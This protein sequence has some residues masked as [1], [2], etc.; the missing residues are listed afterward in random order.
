MTAQEFITEA[1]ALGLRFHR[2]GERL[3]VDAE[4]GSLTADVKRWLRDEKE[5][6]LRA[7]DAASIPEDVEPIELD[8]DGWPVGSIEPAEPCPTCGGLEK[9]WD[10]LGGEHCMACER[11]TL[12]RAHRWAARAAAIRQR[13]PRTKGSEQCVT[14]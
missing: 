5:T 9:W 12:A 2:S 10:L 8:P 3:S 14:R 1:R 6:I 4:Q 13:Q 11:L 7:V